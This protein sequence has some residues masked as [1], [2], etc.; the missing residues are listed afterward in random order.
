RFAVSAIAEVVEAAHAIANPQAR[1][2]HSAWLSDQKAALGRLSRSH[3]LRPLFALLP[4][5]EAI[6]QFLT[7]IPHSDRGDIEAEL[8]M[9]RATPT[10]RAQAEIDA[11]LAR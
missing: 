5:R 4:A 2:A 11:V 10:E 6:P 8:A 1:A 3:D 9:V 7:P